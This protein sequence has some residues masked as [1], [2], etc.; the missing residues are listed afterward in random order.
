M[1]AT[2]GFISMPGGGEMLI[3]GMIGLL[4]FGKRLPEVGNSLG[5]MIVEFKKGLRGIEDDI[6]RATRESTS[7]PSQPTSSEPTA[8]EHDVH[9]EHEFHETGEAT[10]EATTLETPVTDAP[11]HETPATDPT[12]PTMH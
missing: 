1:D 8:G 7:T 12:A 6:E 11:T 4:L 10:P 5:K 9:S 2:L 3:I